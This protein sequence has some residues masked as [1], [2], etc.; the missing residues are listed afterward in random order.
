MVEAIIGMQLATACVTEPKKEID[1]YE[2]ALDI[3]K[4]IPIV[5]KQ[6]DDMI[7]LRTQ[8]AKASVIEQD[9][10]QKIIELSTEIRARMNSISE[11]KNK[12]K[13]RILISIVRNIVLVAF[14]AV[15]LYS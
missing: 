13:F 14:I 12:F 15:F 4:Q 1:A 10:Q 11:M 3:C 2:N 8:I 9:T 6:I 7:D 5:Q